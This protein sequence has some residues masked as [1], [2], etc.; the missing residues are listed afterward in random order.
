MLW[1][2]SV[3]I[4]DVSKSQNLQKLMKAAAIWTVNE[5]MD[6]LI[7]LVGVQKEN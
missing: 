2:S 1:E 6:M 4:Y 5:F 3:N 7:Y